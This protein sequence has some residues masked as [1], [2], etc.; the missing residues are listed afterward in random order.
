MK[1]IS[2]TAISNYY[3]AVAIEQT[4]TN[5]YYLTLGNYDGV[6]KVRI[7][8]EFALAFIKEFGGQNERQ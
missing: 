7:S 1:Q 5:K 6:N 8:E 3:G 4:K 2:N